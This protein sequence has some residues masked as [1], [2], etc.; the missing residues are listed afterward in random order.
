MKQ[1][2][3]GFA[4]GSAL[5]GV[6]AYFIAKKK[7]E[8]NKR[9]IRTECEDTICKMREYYIQTYTVQKAA[10]IEEER[11]EEPSE[12]VAGYEKTEYVE[13]A[14]PYQRDIDPAEM[15]RPEEDAPDEYYEESDI[16][17]IRE[18]VLANNYA[19]DRRDAPPEIIDADDFGQVHGYDAQEWTYYVE[20][21]TYC[22]K[23]DM[24][25]DNSYMN[26]GTCLDDWAENHEMT[27]SIYVRNHQL[28]CDYKV[29]KMFCKSPQ[30]VR[31]DDG[32]DD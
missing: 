16:R 5:T 6:T 29:D 32:H 15:E 1:F 26:F 30:F 10:V 12:I 2:I 22:D 31:T 27:E 3:F 19:N 9:E 28:A 18:G 11:K 20:D 21:L 7:I 25:V 4:V 13:K 23:E 24:A 17:A 8:N 14:E